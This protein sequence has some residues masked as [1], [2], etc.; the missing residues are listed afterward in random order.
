MIEERGR[1]GWRG[2]RPPDTPGEGEATTGSGFVDI[3][4]R[5]REGDGA[6]SLGG[7]GGRGPG[8][9]A[10]TIVATVGDVDVCQCYFDRDVYQFTVIGGFFPVLGF[11]GDRVG[12]LRGGEKRGKNH[13]GIRTKAT[14]ILDLMIVDPID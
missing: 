14:L 5:I 3:V 7:G 12:R 1:G 11:V 8:K 9:L 2:D 13:A 4:G 10:A 6:I